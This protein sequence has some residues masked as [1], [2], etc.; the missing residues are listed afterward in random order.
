MHPFLAIRKRL[1]LTQAEIAGPLG[2]SQGN[3]SFYEKGQTVPPA[4]A[5]KL[6][7]FARSRGLL[8]TFDHVYG[9][10]E[11]PPAEAPAE[12]AKPAPIREPEAVHPL[13]FEDSDSHGEP[14]TPIAL[15]V[16]RRSRDREEEDIRIRAGLRASDKPGASSHESKPR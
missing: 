15:G 4:V 7:E 10:A 1:G 13:A 12:D 6:I 16:E 9:A 3:V 5:G 11:L 2:V 8:I 14:C